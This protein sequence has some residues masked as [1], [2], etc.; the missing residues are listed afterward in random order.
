MSKEYFG[1]KHE[2]YFKLMLEN[3]DQGERTRIYN[4]HLKSSFTR[5]IDSIIR[6]YGLYVKNETYTQIHDD[7][8]SYIMTKLTNFNPDNGTK[9][10]SYFGTIA[11]RYLIN[12][13]KNQYKNTTKYAC[14][15]QEVP[16]I[17]NRPDMILDTE[18]EEICFQKLF[19]GIIDS[20]ETELTKNDLTPDER[21]VGCSLVE[22][23]TNWELIFNDETLIKNNKFNKNQVRFIIKDMTNLDT[24]EI[25][26]ALKRFKTV[27]NAFKDDFV[28][29]KT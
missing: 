10:Y 12:E 3:E 13:I 15:E 6:T 29:D 24:N 17:I 21:K 19:K 4:T 8:L 25:R 2:K 23:F 27:Y 22:I 1:P 14:Y 26:N 16:N 28:S 7:C 11:K 20:I 18:K 5:L 9:A